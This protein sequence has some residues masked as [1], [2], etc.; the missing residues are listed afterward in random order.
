MIKER[1][2]FWVKKRFLKVESYLRKIAEKFPHSPIMHA[3]LIN[4]AFYSLSLNKIDNS[5][6][7][8][9]YTFLI[10]TYCIKKEDFFTAFSSALFS[11]LSLHSPLF[12][13]PISLAGTS[14]YLSFLQDPSQYFFFL[15]FTF[16]IVFVRLAGYPLYRCSTC[17]CCR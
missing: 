9:I 13:F 3:H 12:L 8:W 17:A 7:H 4:Y 6:G 16:S 14:S 1:C 10:I 15:F 5:L 2:Q 11:P